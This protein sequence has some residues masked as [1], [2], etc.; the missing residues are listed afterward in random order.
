MVQC[1]APSLGGSNGDADV[2]LDF[3]LPDELLEA[4]G[5]QAGIKRPVLGSGL[6]RYNTS[7]FNLTPS[8]RLPSKGERN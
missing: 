8:F 7:Y 5:A 3:V 1:L 6:T 4:A 2:F